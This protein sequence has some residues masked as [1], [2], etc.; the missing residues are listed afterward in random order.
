[1]IAATDIIK[2]PNWYLHAI[3]LDQPSLLFVKTNQRDLSACSFLDHRFDTSR[4][5]SVTIPLVELLGLS[6]SLDS[7]A[8]R[9]VFHTAFCC[10][11]LVARCLDLEQANVSLK[12]P[13]V[14]MELA[15]YQR[16]GHPV[17]ANPTQARA[18][19][20]LVTKLLFRQ[21]GL[22]QSVLVKPTNTVN[23]II[24]AMMATDPRSKALL[25]HSDLESF[26]ISI[27]KKG[28]QGRGFV[29]QL[30]TILLIDSA[31]ARQLDSTRLL[32]M[33]DS[34]IAAITWHLQL[35]TFFDVFKQYDSSRVR[36]L[37]CDRLLDD[38]RSILNGIIDFFEFKLLD[39]NFTR[40]MEHAPLKSNA[41]T[42]GQKFDADS[43][44]QDYTNA[45][46][47]FTDTLEV[48][49]PWAEQL[50]F[51]Y[52]YSDKISNPL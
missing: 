26:L 21:F 35:E 6:D 27:L 49:I 7:A 8:P 23:N 47:Q 52:S 33:T 42:P 37:H 4:L 29:R 15:N 22:G 45:R 44:K 11:T 20:T 30:F 32:R 31:E 3:N 19:Y 16:I 46:R 17:L 14:L 51:R 13:A 39:Q 18:I 28:E 50:S 12:E 38:P 25:L 48:I 36:S 5:P 41:K 43:R 10:S 24:L 1:V 2:D 40:L 34:Q 9:F